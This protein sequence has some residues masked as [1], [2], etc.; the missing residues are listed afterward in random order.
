MRKHQNGF[1]VLEDDAFISKWAY[2]EGRLDHD[3]GTLRNFK[4]WIPDGG[5]VFDIGAFIG[6][7]T[8]FYSNCV[9]D[10]GA[11]FAF[12]PQPDAY[13]C[14][15]YNM[16]D[17]PN[18][19]CL[20]R[21]LGN[22]EQ[23]ASIVRNTTNAGASRVD[24]NRKTGVLV[25]SL[26]G[27]VYNAPEREVKGIDFIKIDVEGMEPDVLLGGRNALIE[28]RPVMVIEINAHSLVHYDR[29]PSDIFRALEDLNYVWKPLQGEGGTL[30][31]Q[32]DA[33][34]FPA[35]RE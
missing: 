11:V 10:N 26:D 13:E 8:I 22:R 12:E 18:V 4:K 16:K 35:E 24:T 14:L 25:Q 17:K 33:V 3:I 15:K 5:V 31:P 28:F 23:Q 30:H 29:K 27:F 32:W 19:E 21:A 7:H 9:G 34:C 20:N 2:D 6:D 1:A